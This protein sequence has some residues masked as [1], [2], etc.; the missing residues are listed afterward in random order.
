MTNYIISEMR[1]KCD[2][3]CDMSLSGDDRVIAMYTR[4]RY[5]KIQNFDFGNLFYFT[6]PYTIHAPNIVHNYES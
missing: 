5:K 3:L 1:E 4:L 6:I 2:T